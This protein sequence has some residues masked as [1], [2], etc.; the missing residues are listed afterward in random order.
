PVFTPGSVCLHHDPDRVRVDHHAADDL[1]RA[2]AHLDLGAGCTAL[3]GLAFAGRDKAGAAG[4]GAHHLAALYGVGITQ[5]AGLDGAAHADALAG[6]IAHRLAG[7]EDDVVR[8]AQDI[9]F[10][11][12]H[13]VQ[14]YDIA[15]LYVPVGHVVIALD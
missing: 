2:R 4:F 12:G 9:A 3:Q 14:R 8:H 5:G 1:P 11:R 6:D 10:A 7:I 15:N 13:V